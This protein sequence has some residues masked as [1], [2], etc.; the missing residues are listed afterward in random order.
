MCMKR[1][2]MIASI[3]FDP[4]PGKSSNTHRDIQIMK[5]YT[6]D[7]SSL[8][9]NCATYCPMLLRRTQ[10]ALQLDTADTMPQAQKVAM[11]V[12]NVKNTDR[13]TSTPI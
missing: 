10:C 1:L 12:N 7:T 5:Q 13:T 6:D 11:R 4:R 8:D 2:P 3:S 9:G